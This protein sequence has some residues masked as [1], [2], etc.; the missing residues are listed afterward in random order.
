[1]AAFTCTSRPPIS[2]RSET[3]IVSSPSASSLSSRRMF[4][5]LPE[6]SG[7]RIRL[8][9]SPASLTS[10]HHHPR[11][12][13]LRRA[14]VCEAQETTTD[15]PV[16]ND[17]TWDSLVLKADGPVL[18]DFWAPWCGPCK[19]I[20]PLVNDLAQQYTGKIK[21]Y[22]LNTDESPST[23]SQYGVRSIPTIMIF[24]NGEKKD[25]IIGAVPKT[26]LTSSI[27]KFLQ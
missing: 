6:S 24:V 7:L 12:S 1:M 5:V 26:T 13:R 9:L 27:D 21:F 20:D 2:L 19:M 16:V 23:P 17:S 18:V 10:I 25:T 22:K 3:K 15:I 14:I 8:S 11:V 4:A